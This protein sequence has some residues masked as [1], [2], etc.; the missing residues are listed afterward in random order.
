M[1]VDCWLL[2]PHTTRLWPLNCLIKSIGPGGKRKLPY[3]QRDGSCPT[4][5]RIPGELHEKRIDNKQFSVLG[6]FCICQSKS[7]KITGKDSV[8][9]LPNIWNSAIFYNLSKSAGLSARGRSVLP[10][11]A[12]ICS[13]IFFSTVGH[14][15][16]YGVLNVT[17]FAMLHSFVRECYQL[18]N[19]TKITGPKKVIIAKNN[20]Y[21]SFGVLLFDLSL[22]HSS[23]V[24]SY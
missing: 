3:Y 1:E 19:C 7:P 21:V 9:K 17:E 18:L 4:V 2:S 20:F 14:F 5:G 24:F 16:C 12:K 10:S 22:R 15:T 23:L 13:S 11:V 8:T 6:D